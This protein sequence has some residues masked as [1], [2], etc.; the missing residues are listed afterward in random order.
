MI[1]SS[2]I[3]Y[4]RSSCRNINRRE[5]IAETEVH[6]LWIHK[7]PCGNLVQCIVKF[8]STPVNTYK[9]TLLIGIMEESNGERHH[10]EKSDKNSK[11]NCKC[12]TNNDLKICKLNK[13]SIISILITSMIRNIQHKTNVLCFWNGKYLNLCGRHLL[14]S[15]PWNKSKVSRNTVGTPFRKTEIIY[16]IG[17]PIR[18]KST[19]GNQTGG[20]SIGPYS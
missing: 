12:N 10:S 3:L 5:I 15:S 4:S 2:I 14:S 20:K 11:R 7:R 18:Y 1:T 17:I 6:N 8:N 19:R 13:G 16:S 9:A